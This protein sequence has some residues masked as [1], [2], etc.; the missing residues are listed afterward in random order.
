MRLTPAFLS[1]AERDRVHHE[2]LRILA[3]VGVRFHG[4]R[5]LPLLEKAGARVDA[6]AGIARI[7]GG[8]VAD[9]L[10]VAPRAFVLGAR[11]PEHDLA[12]P[13]PVTRYA[14]AGSTRP[15]ALAWV[16]RATTTVPGLA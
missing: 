8:L 1:E 6:A 2:S 3:D 12:V 11:N 4:D 5:A 9:A 10:A 14:I 15:R 13:S 16:Q 7:P